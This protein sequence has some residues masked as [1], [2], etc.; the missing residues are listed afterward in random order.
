MPTHHGGSSDLFADAVVI[1][2]GLSGLASAI[3]LARGGMDV[4]LLEPQTVMPPIV[5]ESLDWSAPGLLAELGLPMDELIASRAANWKSHIVIHRSDD[6]KRSYQPGRWLAERPWNVEIRTLHLDRPQIQS[7]TEVM[8]AELGVRTLRERA[9]SVEQRDDRFVAVRTSSGYRIKASWFIDASGA[10][11]SFLARHF[12]LRSHIY[13]PRKVALW[14][15]VPVE[16]EAGG[17][18]LYMLDRDAEYMEWVWEIPVRCGVSS[19]GYVLS[20][21]AM[22][23]KRARGKTNSEIFQEVL[24]RFSRLR[25]AAETDAASHPC[26]T[27]FRCRSYRDTCGPNWIIVGEAASQSDPITGN[28]VTAALRH[29]SEASDIMI[30]CRNRRRIP[31]ASRRAYSLR[32]VEMGRFFNS[33]IENMFYQPAVRQQLGVFA[34]GR[35]YTVPAWLANLVYSRIEPNRLSGSIAF[36]S[37]LASLRMA[38]W[39][40]NRASA[41]LT[42]H[43]PPARNRFP[44]EA[45]TEQPQNAPA[46]LIS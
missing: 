36:T 26:S 20:G 13:G 19:I 6:S 7:M 21:P 32:V 28:G 40:A 1:G 17:T 12:R 22:K 45:A 4:T 14:A 3:H 34:V 15:H 35:A 33:L 9:V 38:A 30:R 46:S 37:V 8:A 2:G 41:Y 24:R 25:E 44:E 29:A 11:S 39:T 18:N 42:R 31:L 23:F 10:Q 27:S 5:G 43:I 16:H